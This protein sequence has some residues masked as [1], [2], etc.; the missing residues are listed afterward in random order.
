ML[1]KSIPIIGFVVVLAALAFVFNNSDNKSENQNK[2]EEQTIPATE[3]IREEGGENYHAVSVPAYINKEYDGRDLTLGRVLAE[4]TSYT[5]YYI[6]YKSGNLTISG[7]MNVPKGQGPFPVLILNHGYI[8]P[9]VY[10]NGRGL[11]REQDYLASRGYVVIH[12]DY[13]NHADSSKDPN[14]DVQ[15]RLGYVEDVINAVMAVQ[16]SSLSYFDKEKIGMLGHSMGGGVTQNI[17]VIKP[18]LVDAAVLFAPVSGDN[19][20][21]YERWTMRRPELAQKIVETY[22]TPQENPDFWHDISSINFLERI[23]TPIV[24]HHGTADDSVPIEW[25][26]RMN[27]LLVEKGKDIAYYIYEGQPHEFTTSWS[28]V[29]Q[30]TVDFFDKHLK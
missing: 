7:I 21:N 17:L 30:R 2:P 15:F 8:D 18:D 5:R 1:K 25:S 28:L 10:T 6:T 12:P 19:L 22:G 29:M 11:R 26:N 27:Q 14:A 24:L 3:E 4:T 20:L 16:N 13:R 9:A 23:K